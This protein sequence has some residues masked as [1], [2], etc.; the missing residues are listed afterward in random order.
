MIWPACTE[1]VCPS[2][3]PI[4]ELDGILG[5]VFPAKVI[6]LSI[7]KNSTCGVFAVRSMIKSSM[8]N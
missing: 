1:I 6:F 4:I 8:F 3:E 5:D 7:A 2:Q